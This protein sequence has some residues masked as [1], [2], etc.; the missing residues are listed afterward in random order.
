MGASEGARSPEDVGPLGHTEWVRGGVRVEAAADTAYRIVREWMGGRLPERE[1]VA[2]LLSRSQAALAAAIERELVAAGAPETLAEA[3]RRGGFDERGR[4]VHAG[5]NTLPEEEQAQEIERHLDRLEAGIGEAAAGA[6]VLAGAAAL[7]DR[8]MHELTVENAGL[9]NLLSATAAELR[10]QAERLQA[11]H[12]DLEDVAHL[13]RELCRQIVHGISLAAPSPA[14]TVYLLFAGEDYDQ[15]G[16]AFDACRGLFLSPEGAREAVERG[17]W[18]MMRP[19]ANPIIEW[20]H[21]AR[22]DADGVRV[23]YELAREEDPAAA[24]GKRYRVFWRDER[25]QEAPF[26][27]PSPSPAGAGAAGAAAG[28][29]G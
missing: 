19:A 15:A 17:E 6:K 20:A 18:R 12:P 28:G 13:T 5:M 3:L 2:G 23:V 10:R 16:N 25:G 21:V 1:E 29:E 14:A 26:A 7:G 8:R 22:L 11:A 27:S 4:P 24:P 9:R